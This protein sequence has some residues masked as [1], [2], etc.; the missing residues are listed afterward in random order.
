M[1]VYIIYAAVFYIASKYIDV[2]KLVPLL[3]VCLLLQVA[4]LS[5]LIGEKHEF[6]STAY[7]D[8]ISDF[9][10]PIFLAV[11]D[12]YKHFVFSY[13]NMIRIMD[14]AYYAYKHDM[15]LNRF[16]YAR[17]NHEQV[18]AAFEGYMEK[19]ASGN[20][21]ADFIYMFDENNLP[22]YQNLP[23]HFYYLHGSRFGVKDPIDGLEELSLD[24]IGLE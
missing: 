22:S 19:A 10:D 4:D 23:L 8:H 15:T 12:R 1:T 2:K 13:D 7:E 3:L 9:D 20:P 21:E 16:Y 18:D 24:D 5:E 6:Y 14:A 17:D 11:V